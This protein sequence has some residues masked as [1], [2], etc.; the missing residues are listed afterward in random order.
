VL[1]NLLNTCLNE[2]NKSVANFFIGNE[3][4]EIR[5]GAKRRLLIKYI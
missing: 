2:N 5:G 3:N 1:G 4:D